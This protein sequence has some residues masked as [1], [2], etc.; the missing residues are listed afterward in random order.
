MHTA[1]L[2]CLRTAVVDAASRNNGN[3]A[4]LAYVKIVIN[5]LAKSA[6]RENNGNVQ[7]LI[8]S[9]RLDI[10][11][12]SGFVGLLH[13]LDVLRG[14]LTLQATV[15]S[16]GVRALRNFVKPCDLFK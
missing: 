15:Y 10:D 5:E 6:L 13:D 9:S 1:M 14:I 4:I 2:G 12:N 16:Q 3:V 11:I 8:L 7:A